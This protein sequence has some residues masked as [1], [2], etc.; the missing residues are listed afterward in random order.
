MTGPPSHFF[1]SFLIARG[2]VCSLKKER[3][4][5][6][7]GAESSQNS[8]YSISL[9]RQHWVT[10]A[11]T[12]SMFFKPLRP[13]VKCSWPCWIQ[14]PICGPNHGTMGRFNEIST[15]SCGL[16]L[17]LSHPEA[18]EKKRFNK[19]SALSCD[20]SNYLLHPESQEKK[21]KAI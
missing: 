9:S 15:L 11:Y 2:N 20:L 8:F 10:H 6:P 12:L 4:T 3:G 1:F 16:P 14:L 5:Y 13:K 19:I 18:Q 17:K 21:K 7:K